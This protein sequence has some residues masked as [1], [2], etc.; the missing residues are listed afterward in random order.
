[1]TDARADALPPASPLDQDFSRPGR[2]P[3]KRSGWRLVRGAWK[4][5]VGI[6]DL[7]VL[8]AMLLFFGL[9]FAA[10]NARPGT[11]AITDGALLLK[12]DGPIVEQPE[13]ISPL[14]MLSGGKDAAS[15]SPAR[16]GPRDR[17]G[18]G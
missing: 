15:I 2:K 18:Q 12:L 16:R 14:A 13:T 5:L 3:G 6:K 8:A 4:L 1:M 17:R 10:L 9:I 11:K 7:L